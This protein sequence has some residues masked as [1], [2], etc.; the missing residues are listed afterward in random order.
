[1]TLTTLIGWES[2]QIAK[3]AVIAKIEGFL[4]ARESS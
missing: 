2:S 3:I 4:A 1:M